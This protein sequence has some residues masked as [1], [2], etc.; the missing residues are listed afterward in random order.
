M[1]DSATDSPQTVRVE[2]FLRQCA[3]PD[4]VDTLGETVARSRR[5]E[6]RDGHTDV[7]IKTW[8]SVCPAIESLSDSGRSVS[9]TVD[10]FQSWADREGYTLRPA[11]ERRETASRFGR[12][13]T[14]EEIRVPVVCVA[15]YEDDDL[16]CVAPCTDGDR[17]YT[18]E[19]CLDA[20]EDG[21]SVPFGNRDDSPGLSSGWPG[22]SVEAEESE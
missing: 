22:E 5:L 15:V 1:T 4:V 20:L 19:Q 3:S 7:R 11:F 13:A 14:A 2:V 8:G 18:V 21:Q 10:A 17:T 16:E 12:G 6:Q 9:V